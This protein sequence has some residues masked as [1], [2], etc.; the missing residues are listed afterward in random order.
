[1]RIGELASLTGVSTRSLRYYEQ[2][3]LLT[4]VR[5]ENGYRVY[6]ELDAVRAA[7]IKDALDAGLTLDEVRPALLDGCL[8]VPL[9]ESAYCADELRR[10]TD[11]LSAL[12]DRI[13]ALQ[14]LRDRLVRHIDETVTRRPVDGTG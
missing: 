5:A 12:D 6:G 7:N 3:G 8:D 10:A 1:M 11:R 4:P 13:A 9:R 2:Q 14:G